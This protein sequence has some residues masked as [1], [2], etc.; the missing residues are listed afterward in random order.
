MLGRGVLSPG[1]LKDLSPIAR[2]EP[3]GPQEKERVEIS[4]EVKIFKSYC[5]KTLFLVKDRCKKD[6][7]SQGQ[8]GDQPDD[9]GAG[10]IGRL[11]GGHQRGGV[12]TATKERVSVPSHE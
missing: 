10:A 1:Q 4:Y 6:D 12:V 9:S 7:L 3:V 11:A 8:C 2:T 5:D